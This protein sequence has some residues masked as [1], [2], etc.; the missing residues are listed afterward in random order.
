MTSRGGIRKKLVTV[1]LLLVLSVLVLLSYWQITAQKELLQVELHK[2]TNLLLENLHSR[3]LF[4]AD[5]MKRKVEEEIASFRLFELTSS[6]T[7]ITRQNEELEFIILTDHDNNIVVHTADA[8]RQQTEYHDG[9]YPD[10]LILEVDKSTPMRQDW[11]DTK[12]GQ[13]LQNAKAIQYKM[14][15]E[16]GNRRWGQLILS[17]SLSKLQTEVNRSE[18]ENAA[19]IKGHTIRSLITASSILLITFLIISSLSKRLSA[20]IIRLTEMTHRLSKGDFSVATQ[21]QVNDDDEVGVLSRQFSE[22]AI[23][24]EKAYHDLEEYNLL[25]ERKVNE[26]TQQLNL[27]N[28]EL[29]KAINDLEE[30]QQQLVHSE[31]MAAL[32]QLV[33]SIAHEINTPLGAIQAS[34]GNATKYY[35]AYANSLDMLLHTSQQHDQALFLWLLHNARPMESLTTREERVAKRKAIQV[36]DEHNIQRS[37]DI[38]E[39]LIDMGLSHEVEQLLPFIQGDNYID[40]IKSAHQLTGIMRSNQ[41]IYSATARA[42]KIVF[43]LKNFARQDQFGE[44]QESDI[45]EGI[46]TVLVLYSGL[47]KQGCEV[48]KEFDDLPLIPCH[49]DELNQVWTNLIHNALQAMDYKGTLTLRSRLDPAGTCPQIVVQIEDTG[50]GIPADL[51]HRVW[52]SFFTTKESGEGSGLGL[53]ICKRIIEKHSGRLFFESEPGRTVFTVVLPLQT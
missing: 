29:V 24:L 10:R 13:A 7:E 37:A 46:N 47:L 22:M 14:P 26:R 40:V 52:E 49:A 5:Q 38:A 21:V 45:N 3:A 15:V 11:S 43:A 17:Y 35:T 50:H 42:S 20:P 32:G 41:T 31:K 1:M 39:M 48:V 28:E 30:S 36:L 9:D 4:Q 23:N 51:Q 12:V 18:Q 16:V 53:G 6:L 19:V 44:K 25:L 27:R 33:A 34:A 8:S 2:Q